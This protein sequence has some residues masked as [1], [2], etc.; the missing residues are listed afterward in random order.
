[1]GALAL[2]KWDAKRRPHPDPPHSRF[3]KA[4]TVGG[5]S[6]KES[7]YGGAG[8]ARLRSE[9]GIIPSPGR[10]SARLSPS[11]DGGG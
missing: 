2:K 11:P 9:V 6:R 5:G 10:A 4:L 1:M 7:F 3:A 8:L